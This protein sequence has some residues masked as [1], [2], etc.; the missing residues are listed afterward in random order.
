MRATNTITFTRKS[1]FGRHKFSKR[2]TAVLCIYLSYFL[3][4]IS[5]FCSLKHVYPFVVNI[6]VRLN[7]FPDIVLIIGLNYDFV[8]FSCQPGFGRFFKKFE[9]TKPFFEDDC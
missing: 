4:S 7:V 3:T 5:D 9:M 6:L 2:R 8:Q 1:D